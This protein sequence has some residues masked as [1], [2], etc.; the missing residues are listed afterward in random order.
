MLLR[1]EELSVEISETVSEPLSLHC[2]SSPRMNT[3]EHLK[4]SLTD[5]LIAFT[6]KSKFLRLDWD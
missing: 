6:A 2:C 1:S 3:G 5:A 4:T